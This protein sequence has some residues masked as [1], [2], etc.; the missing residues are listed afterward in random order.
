[1]IGINGTY[2][3]SVW[4]LKLLTS[5]LSGKWSHKIGLAIPFLTLKSSMINEWMFYGEL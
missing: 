1:M 3:K 5:A 4:D 2:K